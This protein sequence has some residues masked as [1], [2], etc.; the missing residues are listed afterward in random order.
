MKDPGK[1][2]T[3][4]KHL[5]LLLVAV[6]AAGAV[7]CGGPDEPGFLNRLL[8]RTPQPDS[9]PVM[10]NTE[11]PFRYPTELYAQRVQGN[12]SLRLF[13]DQEGKVH[14][15]STRVVESSGHAAL[16]SAALAGAAELRFAPASRKGRA[17]A[18]TII[19]PVYFRHPEAPPLPGDTGAA[20]KARKGDST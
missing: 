10:L 9:L 6:L 20:R 11:P 16:D 7:A 18:V 8:D 4:F 3:R 17:L 15:D 12:V 13:I 1:A 19:Y 5:W 14:N 2:G